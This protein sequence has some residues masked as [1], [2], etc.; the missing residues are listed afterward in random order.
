[1]LL[2]GGSDVN[3]KNYLGRSALFISVNTGQPQITRM[4][5]EAGA[6]E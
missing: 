1:M 4:L 5:K 3:T 2:D 6:I